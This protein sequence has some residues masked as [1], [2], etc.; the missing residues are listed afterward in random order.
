[1]VPSFFERNGFYHSIPAMW[2][3]WPADMHEAL[4][5]GF[6]LSLL[7]LRSYPSWWGRSPA[8]MAFASTVSAVYKKDS[9]YAQGSFCG[10]FGAQQ[11]KDSQ[12]ARWCGV[13]LA[14]K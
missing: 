5:M 10:N 12:L 11:G 1:M 4:L 8:V 3:E 7:R 13:N 2:P 6:L 9:I 14:I